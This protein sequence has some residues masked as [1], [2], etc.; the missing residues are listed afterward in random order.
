MLAG[1][2]NGDSL[3]GGHGGG[4]AAMANLFAGRG[5]GAAAGRLFSYFLFDSIFLAKGAGLGALLA[6]RGGG[7]ISLPKPEPITGDSLAIAVRSSRPIP[8]P[9]RLPNQ[10]DVMVAGAPLLPGQRLQQS[11]S[12]VLSSPLF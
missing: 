7:G 11:G 3:K 8:P 12:S 5:N 1:K 4:S 9:P 10:P 2:G 6:G